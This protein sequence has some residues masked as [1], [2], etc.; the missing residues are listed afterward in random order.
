MIEPPSKESG[1]ASPRLKSDILILSRPEAKLSSNESDAFV[2]SSPGEYEIKNINI[3]GVGD[4]DNI[5]YGIDMEG[6]K[7]AHLGFLKKESDNE[8]LELLGNVDI[9]LIPVGGL[10]NEL[11]DSEAA[12][13]LINKLEP[14]IAIPML[15]E[16]K[17]LKTK[18]APLSAFVKESEAKDPPIPKLGIKKKDIN[19]E[20]TKIVILEKV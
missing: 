11:L 15:F 12:M 14:S 2:I 7:L 16:V 1:I 19:E 8:K 6:I 17:G 18:R 10:G 13:K 9:I 4:G 20:E 3:T 5:I